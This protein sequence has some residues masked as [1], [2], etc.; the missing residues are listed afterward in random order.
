MIL[1]SGRKK[2]LQKGI[3]SVEKQIRV[4]EEKLKRAEL[5]DNIELVEYYRKEIEA[6]KA[7]MQEKKRILDKGG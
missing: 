5:E 2:K 7:D 3:K 4:H 6:K 1:M